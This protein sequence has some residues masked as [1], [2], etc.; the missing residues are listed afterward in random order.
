MESGKCYQLYCAIQRKEIFPV[1][2]VIYPSNNRGEVI[3]VGIPRH[4]YMP[5]R[6]LSVKYFGKNGQAAEAYVCFSACYCCCYF[7]R[8]SVSFNFKYFVHE[9]RH[10]TDVKY[11]EP[12]TRISLLV[13]LRVSPPHVKFSVI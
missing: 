4:I 5:L 10:S 13:S 6:S 9:S 12:V 2:S 3:F 1:D 8:A 7:L 11:E